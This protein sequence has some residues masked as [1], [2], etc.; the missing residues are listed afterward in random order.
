MQAPG[1][2]TLEAELPGHGLEAEAGASDQGRQDRGED[3]HQHI[4]HF[5][6]SG[7]SPDVPVVVMDLMS[8]N[9]E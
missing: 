6:K 3:R 9:S 7:K 8:L 5:R 4:R 1:A 2:G